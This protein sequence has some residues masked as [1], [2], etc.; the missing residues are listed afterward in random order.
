MI[1]LFEVVRVTLFE[2]TL[3]LAQP[4]SIL[5]AVLALIFFMVLRSV[6]RILPVDCALAW[7]AARPTLVLELAT[8]AGASGK[9]AKYSILIPQHTPSEN[10]IWGNVV[11]TEAARFASYLPS[12]LIRAWAVWIT[13]CA[14]HTLGSS[15]CGKLGGGPGFENLQRG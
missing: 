13:C 11:L 14:G 4:F 5:L 12:V 1:I 2:S 6:P 8:V 3:V 9:L 15:V 7:R 10:E